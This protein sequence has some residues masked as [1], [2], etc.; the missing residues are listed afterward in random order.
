MNQ[1]KTDHVRLLKNIHQNTEIE[2][3]EI[4]ENIGIAAGAENE[5]EVEA[6]K[7][8]ESP[9]ESL[10]GEERMIGGPQMLAMRMPSKPDEYWS[11]LNTN[12]VH[13]NSIKN[14]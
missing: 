3:E 10:R 7:G 9:R 4:T 11:K 5:E 2:T 12:N 14:P 8:I 6:G 1:Y 13:T